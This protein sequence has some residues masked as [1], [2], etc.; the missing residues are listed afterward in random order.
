MLARPSWLHKFDEWLRRLGLP[1]QSV[2]TRDGELHIWLDQGQPESFAIAIRP[3]A[4]QAPGWATTEQFVVGYGGSHDLDATRERWLWLV[5]GL[6]R[7]I[8]GR[9][10]TSFDVTEGLF[11][12][13]MPPE[14]QFLRL[15]PFCAVERSSVGSDA[16]VEV[17]VRA[18]S[19]CNQN[20]PF[21]SAPDQVTPTHRALLDAL[22]RAAETFPG[23]MVSLTGGEPTL[24]AQ[25]AD[26]LTSCL[27][28]GAIRLVQVQTNAVAFAS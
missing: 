9:L 5:V 10:P 2:A 20:C 15:F 17:L 27:E 19:K 26:E 1:V 24:R 6:I 23:A 22:A 16:V 3:R 18:T 4:S 28:L 11:E 14:E 12:A 7:R 21:C 13:G 25:F 8:E